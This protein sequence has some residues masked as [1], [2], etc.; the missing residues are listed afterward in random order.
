MHHDVQSDT[1]LARRQAVD[2]LSATLFFGFS[3]SRL[4]LAD[5]MNKVTCTHRDCNLNVHLPHEAT[6]HDNLANLSS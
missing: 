3:T 5:A 1:N 4:V 6:P 2:Y